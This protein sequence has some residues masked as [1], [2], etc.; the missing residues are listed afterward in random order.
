MEGFSTNKRFLKILGLTLI[1]TYIFA[2]DLPSDMAE[3][4]DLT[5][6]GVN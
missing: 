5:F 4:F 2:L 1:F 3:S 6:V